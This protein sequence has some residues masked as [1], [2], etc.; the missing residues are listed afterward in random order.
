M[1]DIV[2]QLL[3]HA[4]AAVLYA[5]LGA[6]F[7]ITRWRNTGDRPVA[8]PMQTWERAAIA[9][10]LGL[11]ALGLYQLIFAGGAMHFSAALALALMLWL[12][13]ILY[14]AESFQARMEGMQP[15]ILPLA[16]ACAALPLALPE[17]RQVAHA[18]ALGFM[19]H[20]SRA[21]LAYSLLT[22]AAL[23]AIF[24]RFTE[25]ALH[26]HSLTRGLASL[27]P[28]LVMETLL[29]RMLGLGFACLSLTLG[30]GILFSETLFGKPFALDH[31]TIFA[32]ASWLIFATLLYGRLAW[33]WRGKRALR[34]TLSGFSLLVLAYIGSRFVAEVLLGRL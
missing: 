12:A 24:M 16:A 10:A 14:W 31:K 28:L 7:W 2:I 17:T 5:L 13:V 18:E 27:P 29:F 25:N 30:S 6:H 4:L 1:V 3:P 11:Q 19:L 34:W 26:S 33:G 32:L 23:H 15:M 20:F 22:L 9:I 21:M 8:A